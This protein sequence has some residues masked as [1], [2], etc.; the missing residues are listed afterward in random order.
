MGR[1]IECGHLSVRDVL[2][3]RIGSAI[4]LTAHA[5]PGRRAGGADQIDD[6]GRLTSGW[7]RQLVLMYEKSRCSI[8]FHLLVP[9]GR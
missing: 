7:P 3:F 1:E 2:T 6:H 9:G 5:Q 4:E 8:L